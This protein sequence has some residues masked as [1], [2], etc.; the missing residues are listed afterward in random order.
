MLDVTPDDIARLDD[1]QMRELVGRLAS[2]DAQRCGHSPHCV[3]WGGDQNANDEGSDVEARLRN[4]SGAG[5][6]LTVYQVKKSDLKPA[7]I[8]KEMR[9]DGLIRP[10]FP[11]LA[12]EGGKYV[13]VSAK[14]D[15][16]PRKLEKR[17]AAMRAALADLP[18]GDAI[19]LDFI[20]RGRLVRWV[21][22]HPGTTAWVREIVGRP[23]RGWRGY[24]NWSRPKVRE[25]ESLLFDQ[26]KRFHFGLSG[27]PVTCL[28]AIWRL[29]SMLRVPGAA[30]RLVGLSGVGKTRVVQALFDAAVGKGELAPADVLYTDLE[31]SPDPGPM[32]IVDMLQAH[33]RPVTLVIDNCDPRLHA[34]LS[35]HCTGK[36]SVVRLLTVE[37]DVRDEQFEDTDVVRVEPASCWLMHDFLVQRYPGIAPAD[38]SE[39]ARLSGGNWRLAVILAEAVEDGRGAV[40]ASTPR[41]DA[42]FYQR[43]GTDDRLLAAAQACTLVYSFDGESTDGSSTHLHHLAALAQLPVEAMYAYVATL[44]KRGLVQ[45]RSHWRA[46]LPQA[47]AE[48]L[49]R[50]AL[51]STFPTL[52]E[53]HII[54][55]GDP[56]L[57]N[58]FARRLSMLRGEPKAGEWCMELMAPAGPF[59]DIAAMPSERVELFVAMAAAAPDAALTAVSRAMDE[60]DGK[61]QLAP[62]KFARLVSDLSR[63]SALADQCLDLL[64]N[65]V[66][67]EQPVDAELAAREASAF[68]Q[69]GLCAGPLAQRRL[70]T[71]KAWLEEDTPRMKSLARDALMHAVSIYERPW[72]GGRFHT[73]E[74]DFSPELGYSPALRAQTG[75]WY[76]QALQLLHDYAVRSE[77]NLSFARWLT[78]GKVMRELWRRRAVRP[79]VEKLVMG[80]KGGEFWAE[81]YKAALEQEDDEDFDS[82]DRE[83]AKKL[84]TRLAPQNLAD[85]LRAVCLDADLLMD[86]STSDSDREGYFANIAQLTKE[87]AIEALQDLPTLEGAMPHLIRSLAVADFGAVLARQAGAAQDR[88]WRCIYSNLHGMPPDR[89]TGSLPYGFL[90]GL[91]TMDR[92]AADACLDEVA[93]HA[94][95]AMHLPA[96]TAAAGFDLPGIE[97]MRGAVARGTVPLT[98]LG[99]L[100]KAGK[101]APAIQISA[102]QFLGDIA[103]LPE[104]PYMIIG[105]LRGWLD[106]GA[107]PD[108]E[109]CDSLHYAC[110]QACR[111]FEPMETYHYSGAR[112]ARVA[113]VLFDGP[114]KAEVAPQ[115]AIRLC[116][117][118]LASPG[119]F[120]DFRKTFDLLCSSHVD[121]L[122]DV[123]AASSDAHLVAGSIDALSY[124][125][126]IRSWEEGMFD[127][128]AIERWCV[129]A[130]ADRVPLALSVV[131]VAEV[132]EHMDLL[133]LTPIVRSLLSTHAQQHP[134]ALADALLKRMVKSAHMENTVKR[135]Q[136]WLNLV[137]DAAQLLGPAAAS[138]VDATR[139]EM[140]EGLD[141]QR[142]A[143]AMQRQCQRLPMGFE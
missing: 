37:Y 101:A 35:A 43:N 66:R 89:Q 22:S 34:I 117:G 88:V 78:C 41:F 62:G 54:N 47:L 85:R 40:L 119:L 59:G 126:S 83:H 14:T 106:E 143:D 91:A 53:R 46:V 80:L 100:R 20:D 138:E 104:A 109:A 79:E 87:L 107:E 60:K 13:I 65:V 24:G 4:L 76:A 27:E 123:L 133:G 86:R 136:M 114:H 129:A 75:E 12:S 16:T 48:Y 3:V 11:Q 63:H 25:Q 99:W 93:G 121:V 98:E 111:Y 140:E 102:L 5:T 134:G 51:S 124:D 135:K 58:S 6:A 52:I 9:P 64:A 139:I 61:S 130:P 97:R 17:E 142:E 26:T 90:E 45:K 82:V 71:L 57:V 30:V 115:L 110:A 95:L 72:S 131:P 23:M 44:V 74:P 118:I 55:A 125:L 103:S 2:A 36:E 32:A 132:G 108:A 42:L 29:R 84:S 137:E 68:F 39:V 28:D 21:A 94:D 10:W 127:A 128:A 105:A 7:E 49:A 112:L 31:H 120:A 116:R 50:N 70:A 33:G 92:A 122:L 69:A 81:A 73:G 96:L 1:K 18:G 67:S 56:H 19:R 8:A 113:A 141:Q 15:A 38:V 77:D